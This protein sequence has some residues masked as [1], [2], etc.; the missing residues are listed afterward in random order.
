M[1][2]STGRSVAGGPGEKAD[3]PLLGW[4]SRQLDGHIDWAADR[5]IHALIPWLL[6]YWLTHW[7]TWLTGLL[8]DSFIRSCCGVLLIWLIDCP[9]YSKRL[10]DDSASSQRNE[11]VNVDRAER[12]KLSRVNGGTVGQN[13]AKGK[14]QTDIYVCLQTNRLRWPCGR[15]ALR[16]L[17]T[18]GK[19]GKLDPM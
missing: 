8:V 3:V 14:R 7:L 15:R 18:A 19:R 6:I 11:T 2:L 12:R 16:G 10:D 17:Y 9:V 1:K 13:G 5:L 4:S